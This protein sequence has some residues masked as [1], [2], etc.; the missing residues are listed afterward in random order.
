VPEN[1]AQTIEQQLAAV[2]Q[3]TS[4]L[5]HSFLQLSARFDALKAVFC[6]LHPEVA[7]QLEERIRIEQTA[8]VK[9]FE[10]LLKSIEFLRATIPGP[11]Q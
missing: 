7:I 4:M 11:I 9:Q 5:A 1:P 3:V 2:L 10:E 6:E 8:S